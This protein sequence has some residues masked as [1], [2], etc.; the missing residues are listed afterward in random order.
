MLTKD[1]LRKDYLEKKRQFLENS[2]KEHMDT[3]ISENLA[4]F[5]PNDASLKWGVYKSLPRE[6]DPFLVTLKTQTEWAYPR[7]HGDALQYYIPTKD[8]WIK[9]EHNIEEPNPKSSEFV[10][11]TSL[12][13]VIMP[14]I[15]FDRRGYRLGWGKAFYDRTLKN[16]RGKK[17]GVAYSVQLMDE[18]LP[19]DNH[20]IPVDIIVTEK[21]VIIVNER[22]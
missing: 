20:D 14:A 15:A 6:A 10:E 13:G 22:N 7:I 11:L 12:S 9:N 19:K 5:I 2:N 4:Q 18:L 21:D 16:F 3:L 17:I 1:I 8:Q